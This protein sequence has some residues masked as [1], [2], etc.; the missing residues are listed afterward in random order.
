MKSAG[1]SSNSD[2]SLVMNQSRDQTLGLVGTSEAVPHEGRGARGLL[3]PQG[4]ATIAASSQH[5]QPQAK[6]S[7]S[8]TTVMGRAA[9]WLP[10]S[11]ARQPLPEDSWPWHTGSTMGHHGGSTLV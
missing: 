10:P 3:H 5:K 4:L 2:L 7:P 8:Q 9:S 6:N 11:A 1:L